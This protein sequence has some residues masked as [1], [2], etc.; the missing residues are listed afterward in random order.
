MKKVELIFIPTPVVGHQVSNMEF[1]KHL[2]HR[3]DRIR[4]TVLSLKWLQSAVLDA[5]T[6]LLAASLPD[7]IQ[8]I[9]VPKV[10]PP[11]IDPL[12]S[13]ASYVYAVIQSYIPLVRNVVSN[14]VSRTRVAG[15]VLDLFCA[16]M[17]DVATELDLP[18]YIYVT[19]NAAY[20]GL[21]FYLPIR[22]S[23]NSSEFEISDPENLIPGFVNPVPS[24]VL[25][26]AV[27]NKDGGYTAYVKI[28]ER[29]M[30]AKGIMINTFEELEPYAVNCFSNGQYPPI[31]PV[32]PV[33]HLNGLPHPE[34][35]L[36]QREMVMKWLDYQPQSSVVFLCFGS[37]GLGR[38][39]EPQVKEMALG[40]EQSGCRF[41]WSLRV[42]PPPQKDAPG[43]V[44]YK[45]PED[46][47]PEGYR[48][49][50]QGGG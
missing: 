39:E 20:L 38:F 50:I 49:R 19:S 44:H 27:Y 13:S 41:L 23:Q 3:D 8:F 5:Y 16:P 30:D 43:I 9:D 1:A 15:L 26:T 14:I 40:L 36:G 35:D 46:M 32:G 18:A 10:E 33:L 7:R 24:C 6:K 31:Y 21:M 12:K 17:I 11:S 34:L 45:K 28:A 37:F 2:I 22:H 25:P 48:E 29:F 47:L 4:I 42:P